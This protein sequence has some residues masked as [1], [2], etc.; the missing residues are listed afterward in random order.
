MGN[1][2][3]ANDGDF[4]ARTYAEI[5]GEVSSRQSLGLPNQRV[6]KFL[7]AS[8]IQSCISLKIGCWF[9]TF[10]NS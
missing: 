1:F 8:G 7:I 4:I 5:I 6:S 3:T 2:W 10:S 9:G